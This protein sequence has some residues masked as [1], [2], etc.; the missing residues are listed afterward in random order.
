MLASRYANA[1]LGDCFV[2]HLGMGKLGIFVVFREG[3]IMGNNLGASS[4]VWC[5]HHV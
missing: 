2:A 5:L 4:S 1:N 3:S